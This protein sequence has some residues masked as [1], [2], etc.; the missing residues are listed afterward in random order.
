MEWDN[1]RHTSLLWQKNS[2]YS[3]ERPIEQSNRESI[4][5]KVGQMGQGWPI[6]TA[7]G[8]RAISAFVYP[9]SAI[10]SKVEELKLMNPRLTLYSVALFALRF[11]YKE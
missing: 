9:G 8:L 6:G 7:E 4:K 1:A 10:F 5:R 3:K 2:S 11:V